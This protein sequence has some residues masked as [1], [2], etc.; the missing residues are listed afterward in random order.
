MRKRK[1]AK[2]ILSVSVNVVVVNGVVHV[3]HLRVAPLERAGSEDVP[4]RP[5]SPSS[6]LVD[7]VG[8]R[9]GPPAN[10]PGENSPGPHRGPRILLL[11]RRSDGLREGKLERV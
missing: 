4:P 3:C 2:N 1:T 5:S 6:L 8:Q 7:I 9:G 11:H 10:P